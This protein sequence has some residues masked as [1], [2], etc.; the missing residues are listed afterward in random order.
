MKRYAVAVDSAPLPGGTYDQ[1]IT[2]RFKKDGNVKFIVNEVVDAIGRPLRPDEEDWLDLRRAIHVADLVC[3]RGEN[4][5]WIRS[6]TLALP[7]RAPDRFLPWIPLIQEIFGRMTHDHL[8]MHLALDTDPAPNRYPQRP[9][10]PLI[11]AVALLSGGL[12]SACAAVEI[13]RRHEHPCFVSYGASPHVRRAQKDVLSGLPVERGQ[14][15]CIAT[16]RMNLDHQHP[17]VPLPES[18]LSQRSRT[19]LFTGVAAT[20]AAAR[21]ID[22]VTV[23]ENGVM[24]INCPLTTGRIGGFSTHTAHLDVLMLMGKLFSEVLG[25]PVRIDNPLLHKTKT[26]VISTLVA[27]SLSDLIPKTTPAG[28]HDRPSTVAYVYPV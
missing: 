23:G 9:P 5:E 8:D 26:E 15:I 28:W 16:F 3:H 14:P 6:I 17:E 20:L 19:L 27:E 7:L 24:A 2:V 11:D 4:E 21:G 22:T 13:L 25:K 10:P 18:E 12:D 1:T